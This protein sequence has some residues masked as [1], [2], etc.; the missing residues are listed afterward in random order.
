MSSDTI[1]VGGAIFDG[2]SLREELT[3][4]AVTDGVVSAVGDDSIRDL[5]GPATRI[6][7]L[8][9]GLLSPGFVDAHIHPVEGGLER[10]RCDLSGANT[11]AEY[12][13]LIGEYARAHPDI[14][15]I[16]GGGWQVA[17]FADGAPLAADLDAVIGDRPA[18]LSN[19]D[20]HGAWVSTR[21]LTMA[22][23]HSGTPDPADGRIERDASGAPSGTLQEGARLL[24]H[25]LV[26]ADTDEEN[27]SALLAAQRHLLSH[28]ITGWQDAIVGNYGGHTDT[29]GVYLKAAQNGD[30]KAR[31][32]AALWWDRNRGLE[33]I[34]ELEERRAAANHPL[35]SAGTV[36][37]MQDG[38]PENQTAAMI[39]PYLQNGCRCERGLSFVDPAALAE[40][41]TALDSRGFQVH[42]HAI[43][44]RAV[45]ECLNAL[46]AAAGAN[47]VSANRHHIAHLQIVHPADIERF[48]PLNATVNMQALWASFDSQMLSLN[49]PL[50]GA[51]RVTWQYPFAELWES[52]AAFAAGSDWPVTT[53]DPW[54]GL[55]VA[56]N[57]RLPRDHPDYSAVP[58]GANQ[59]L[60]L[61]QG[62]S[63]YTS[64]SAR[65]NGAENRGSIHV[66]AVADFAIADRN[67]FLMPQDEIG[68]TCTIATW[69]AG[70]EV[71][72]A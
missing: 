50:L 26:P 36:K 11:K 43:G 28:G 1:F 17:A 24:V 8:G 54:A 72:S 66:G 45:R 23:L 68:S 58:L 33:Q 10:M 37:I 59:A 70:E 34:A 47:G 62:L 19:R 16:L 20:H 67:A 60:T 46:E 12:L 5:A 14:P 22:G 52:G 21:A 3:A 39:D 35:F 15:W 27:Y 49:V 6:V 13:A 42:F 71:Y 29:A 41:V 31:V 57:R 30:L 69:V 55:H 65:I 48:A 32:V 9:G 64:G 38:I 61:A 44:D 25:D 63:A 56:V 18:F 53:P 2:F 7:E 51:E 4:V 40:T